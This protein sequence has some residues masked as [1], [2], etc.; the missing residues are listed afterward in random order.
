MRA[1]SPFLGCVLLPEITQEVLKPRFECLE[2]EFKH[3]LDVFGE[4]FRRGDCRRELPTVLGA[5]VRLD[6]ALQQ[7]RDRDLLGN[8]PPEASLRFLDIVDRYYATVDALEECGRLMHT[9]R[10]ERYWGDYAL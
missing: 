6:H 7:I 9:L 4:C 5:L 3:M 8:L 10:I 1:S 2:I